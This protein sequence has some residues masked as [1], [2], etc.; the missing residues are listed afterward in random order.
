MDVASRWTGIEK[1]GSL[2]MRRTKEQRDSAGVLEEKRPARRSTISRVRGT[3]TV[4]SGEIP[5]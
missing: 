1:H 2:Y 4:E 5:A 3:N